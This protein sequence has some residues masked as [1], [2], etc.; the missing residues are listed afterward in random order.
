LSQRKIKA[1]IKCPC[2]YSR[3]GY[4]VYIQTK[5]DN[6]ERNQLANAFN[7]DW[8]R[9][10]YRVYIGDL[11]TLTHACHAKVPPIGVILDIKYIKH[12][13]TECTIQ[14]SDGCRSGPGLLAVQYGLL[15]LVEDIDEH[16]TLK[17]KYGSV[18]VRNPPWF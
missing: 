11:V 1:D 10:E 13:E 7:H 16:N 6:M 2:N 12:R 17:E 3:T 14:W 18:Y 5:A 8:Q 4:I 15:I 9:W